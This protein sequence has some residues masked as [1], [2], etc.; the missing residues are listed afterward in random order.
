MHTAGQPRGNDLRHQVD[1][2]VMKDITKKLIFAEAAAVT[3][4][5]ARRASRRRSLQPGPGSRGAQRSS[6]G[7]RRDLMRLGGSDQHRRRV[8]ETGG[9]GAA[10][11]GR[12]RVSCALESDERTDFELLASWRAGAAAAG[13]ALFARHFR[14]IYRFFETKCPAEADELVQRTFLACVRSKEQFRGE[15]SFTTYLFAIARRE[16]LRV[17]EL[18]R[19]D[20]ARLDFEVSSIAELAPSAR[21]QIAGRE[22]RVRLVRALQDLPADQQVLLELHYWE[23]IEIADLAEIFDVLPVTIRSRLHRA[24]NALRELML[25]E[26]DAADKIGP[27]LESL[28]EWARRMAPGE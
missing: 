17:L 5:R 20:G 6:T 16:L 28:D 23:G 1:P 12:L 4:G 25:K 27:T 13:Q 18:R 7:R 9:A 2:D 15:S 10:F 24:R 8:A 22:D 26:P 3:A 21:T 19:R 11:D 14:R